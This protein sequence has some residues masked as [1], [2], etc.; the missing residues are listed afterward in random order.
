MRYEPAIRAPRS[1]TNVA[2][3]CD[4]TLALVV[5]AVTLICVT[6]GAQIGV[7]TPRIQPVEAPGEVTDP[8]AKDLRDAFAAFGVDAESATILVRTLARHR[9]PRPVSVRLRGMSGSVPWPP[10]STRRSWLFEWPG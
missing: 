1:G 10:P 9:Q 3:H 6:A 4:G 8:A 5:V 2:N 7:S